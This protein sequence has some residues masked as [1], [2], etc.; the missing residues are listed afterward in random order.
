M[1][2]PVRVA[3][4]RIVQAPPAQPPATGLLRF[5]HTPALEDDRWTA[6]Y[7]YRPE[8]PAE[9][10]RNRSNVT[11]TV[12]TNVGTGHDPAPVETIPWML[13]VDDNNSTFDYRAEDLGARAARILDAYTSMLLERELWLGEIAQADNLPNRYFAHNATTD[14][15][16]GTLPTPQAAVAVLM[17]ALGDAGV[18]DG[19]IHCSKS[20]GIRVPDAW[21]NQNTFTDFGF[22]VVAGAGYTGSGPAGQAGP[23]WMYATQVVNVRLGPIEVLRGGLPANLDRASNTLTYRA[24]RIGATDFA[25]PVFACQVTP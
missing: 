21:R 22:V 19:M 17:D 15:T 1:T 16:P 18:G 4:P 11:G 12:A 14:I 13:E 7:I 8:I 10:A 25:G 6:G 9:T 24:Q 5:A 23:N 20:V 3:L 2:A